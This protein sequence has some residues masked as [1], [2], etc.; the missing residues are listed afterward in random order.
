VS[1]LAMP[2]RVPRDRLFVY[3]GLGDR[4]VLPSQAHALWEHWGKPEILWY[5]GNHVG[6]LL[7]REVRQFVRKVLGGFADAKP[8]S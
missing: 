3:A 1:P 4:V 8:L 7:S 5:H 2:T 6:F